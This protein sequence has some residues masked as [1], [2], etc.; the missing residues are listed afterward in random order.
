M[1]SKLL[2][3][4]Q[5][6]KDGDNKLSS[7]RIVFISNH[8]VFLINTIILPYYLVKK[9]AYIESVYLLGISAFYGLI[10]GGYVY[11]EPIK[12]VV[13]KIIKQKKEETTNEIS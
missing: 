13:N 12:K 5:F 10:V 6:I 2:L 7:K 9:E 8:I 11:I 4:S 3:I 1:F